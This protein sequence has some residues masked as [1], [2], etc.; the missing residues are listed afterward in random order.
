MIH[1]CSF[2]FFFFVHLS[3]QRPHQ[4]CNKFTTHLRPSDVVHWSRLPDFRS[5]KRLHVLYMHMCL[6]TH[7]KVIKRIHNC[8]YSKR[9]KI[10]IVLLKLTT[11]IIPFFHP[12]RMWETAFCYK[13]RHTNQTLPNLAILYSQLL[14]HPFCKRMSF[15]VIHTFLPRK[16]GTNSFNVP[17]KSISNII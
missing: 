13:L 10:T 15:I 12:H 6:S 5:T 7:R 11:S 16:K 8:K 1:D 17:K 4:I 2:S 9:T 14:S 3:A